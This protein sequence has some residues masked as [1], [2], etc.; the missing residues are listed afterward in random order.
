MNKEL[1][2]KY[3]GGSMLIIRLAPVDYHRFHFPA[4][5]IIGTSTKIDGHYYS[6]SPLALKQSLEIFCQNKE[7]EK[8]KRQCVLYSD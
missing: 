4:D 7:K 2:N 6:V 8:K 1:A 3:D 5:G